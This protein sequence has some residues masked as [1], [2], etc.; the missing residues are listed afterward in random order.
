MVLSVNPYQLAGNP[1]LH[2]MYHICFQRDAIIVTTYITMQDW[3]KR[4][5]NAPLNTIYGVWYDH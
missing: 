2:H 5:L 1:L 4:L 3:L